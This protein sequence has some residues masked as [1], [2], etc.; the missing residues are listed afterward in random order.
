[1]QRLQ[2]AIL[3]IFGTSE[4][5]TFNKSATYCGI[6][7]IHEFCVVL[8]MA[9]ACSIPLKLLGSLSAHGC[10]YAVNWLPKLNFVSFGI[11]YMNKFSVVK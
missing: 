10:K 6:Q 3:M 8:L 7:V 4:A 5:M 11:H 9:F 2:S 1:M